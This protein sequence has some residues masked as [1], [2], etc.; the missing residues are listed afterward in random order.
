MRGLLKRKSSWA[1]ATVIALT[2]GASLFFYEGDRIT[3]EKCQ[4]IQPGMT[5]S[6]VVAILGE[7]E[8]SIVGL[9]GLDPQVPDAYFAYWHD[10]ERGSI[11]LLVEF[12]KVTKDERPDRDRMTVLRSQFTYGKP[13]SIITRLRMRWDRINWP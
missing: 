9:D 2:L 4:Q 3:E 13:L 6:E 5:F 7:P 1:A 12:T 10:Y 8:P 11:I